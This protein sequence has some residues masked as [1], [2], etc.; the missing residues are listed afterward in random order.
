M[1]GMTCLDVYL[2]MLPEEKLQG[3]QKKI[4]QPHKVSFPL[5]CWD[6][7]MMPAFYQPENKL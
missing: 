5:M 7:F 6:I 4:I 3:I 2:L 1:G